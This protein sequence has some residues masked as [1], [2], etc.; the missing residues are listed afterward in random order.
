MIWIIA[1]KLTIAEETQVLRT[2]I[3]QAGFPELGHALVDMNSPAVGD[4]KYAPLEP[5]QVTVSAGLRQG[6]GVSRFDIPTA[7]SMNA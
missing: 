1:G 6:V 3:G 5:S 4:F 7:S 2:A